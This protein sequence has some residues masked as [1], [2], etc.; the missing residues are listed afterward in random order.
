MGAIGA[1]Q[2]HPVFSLGNLGDN[3]STATFLQIEVGLSKSQT[4]RSLPKRSKQCIAVGFEM[5]LGPRLGR[6]SGGGGLDNRHLGWSGA[7][8]AQ[9]A[10]QAS[11][12]GTRRKYSGGPHIRS[13][14]AILSFKAKSFVRGRKIDPPG[15]RDGSSI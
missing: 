6:Q 15:T 2:A 4:C 7:D 1:L 13:N 3:S 12:D 5:R 14:G 8:R 9:L 10:K 11:R